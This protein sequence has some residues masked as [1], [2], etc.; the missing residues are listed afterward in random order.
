VSELVRQFQK[1][2]SGLGDQYLKIGG[3]F[4][5]IIREMETS[6]A[7]CLTIV[8]SFKQQADSDD[9][10]SL[11]RRIRSM[12]V[13][14]DTETSNFL[15][16]IGSSKTV[17]DRVT[18][19]FTSLQEIAGPVGEI[20]DAADLMSLLALNSM[21]VAIQAGG[22]GGGFTCITDELKQASAATYQTSV[23]IQRRAERVSASHNEFINLSDRIRNF[24]ETIREHLDQD[25]RREFSR[26]YELVTEFISFMENLEARSLEVKPAMMLLMQ[27][28]QNQDI[29]RQSMDHIILSLQE[30]EERHDLDDNERAGQLLLKKQIFNLSHVVLQ[31]IR[32]WL[33]SDLDNLDRSVRTT[34]ELFRELNDSK[35][36]FIA[37]HRDVTPGSGGLSRQV[38]DFR[39]LV[40]RILEKNEA[41]GRLR[42]EI[43]LENQQLLESV[44]DLES[45][46][47]DFE[48]ITALFRNINVMARIEI[49][50]TDVFQNIE[51]AV[52]EM[53][54]IN[55]RIE[56][57]VSR[58]FLIN[59]GVL[60]RN[61]DNDQDF[62]EIISRSQHLQ[63]VFEND[64]EAVLR[65]LDESI[66]TLDTA[67]CDFQLLS[68]EFLRIFN[69]SQEG[70]E[71]IRKGYQELMEMDSSITRQIGEIDQELSRLEHDGEVLEE[72][73]KKIE[74]ILSQF[75][76]YRHKQEAGK[77]AGVH[78]QDDGS[79]EESSVVLF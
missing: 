44:S 65:L 60:E 1:V 72:N 63:S 14:V 33:E 41:S 20:Q 7:A 46:S 27:S 75:T 70:V 28:L 47:R 31:D 26:F 17:L 4:N 10:A 62:R 57:A 49:A 54:G 24:E 36:R 2:Q 78:M 5:R 23:E 77:L 79:A 21:V 38:V 39:D 52:S 29:I 51:N 76:I 9:S 35:T 67:L 68:G 50:R 32:R 18:E 73:R 22:K 58:I 6:I 53:E 74:K 66:R 55:S 3:N 48:A 45:R 59:H 30:L 69:E 12:E 64:I 11:R 25:L 37:R 13:L 61:R 56:Q 16:L 15:D 19:S 34:R 40:G 8:R 71:A 43:W 42:R